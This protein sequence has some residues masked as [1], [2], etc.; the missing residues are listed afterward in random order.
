MILSHC[1]SFTLVNNLMHFFIA[2]EQTL[3][4]TALV[5]STSG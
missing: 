2:P 3:G 5:V 1:I 4:T